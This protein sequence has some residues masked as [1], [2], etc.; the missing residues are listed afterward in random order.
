MCLWLDQYSALKVKG[1]KRRRSRK[2]KR[3]K[4]RRKN[5]QRRKRKTTMT[6]LEWCLVYGT[7]RPASLVTYRDKA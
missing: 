2:R 6:T 1:R 7:E 3:K 4:G 5:K